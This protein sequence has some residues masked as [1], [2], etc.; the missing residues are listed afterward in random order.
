MVGWHIFENHSVG[1]DNRIVADLDALQNDDVATHPT[2]VPNL[3]GSTVKTLLQNRFFRVFVI[4]V[5]I[6][7]LDALSQQA[8]I[9][10]ANSIEASN[11]NMIVHERVL[12]DRQLS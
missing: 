2:V 10:N 1:S 9:T 8:M 11:R 7:K 12:A 5:V 6:V 4:V 3:N